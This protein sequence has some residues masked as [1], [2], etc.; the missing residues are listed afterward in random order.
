MSPRFSPSRLSALFG[1]SRGTAGR[2]TR[3]RHDRRQ[4]SP[5]TEQLENRKLLAVFYRG[6]LQTNTSST[7]ESWAYVVDVDA[8]GT[9]ELWMRYE[10]L[11]N[12]IDIADNPGFGNVDNFRFTPRPGFVG[13][14]VIPQSFPGPISLSGVRTVSAAWN[15]SQ[16]NFT[17]G[18]LWIRAAAGTRIHVANGDPLPLALQVLAG[19]TRIGFVPGPGLGSAEN[20]TVEG[21]IDARLN[22]FTSSPVAYD[23]Y[24]TA[25]TMSVQAAMSTNTRTQFYADTLVDLQ[26]VVTS[27]STLAFVGN[28]DFR[29]IAGAQ[30]NGTLGVYLGQDDFSD[31]FVTG[32]GDVGGNILIDGTVNGSSVTLNTNSKVQPVNIRTGPSG[33][34]SGGGSLTLFNSGLDGGEIDVRSQNYS[35][36]NVSAGAPNGPVPDIGVTINQTAG[37]LRVSAVPRSRGQI[38]LRASAPGSTIT[39][40][41]NVETEAGLALEAGALAVNRPL[42]TSAGNIVLTGDTV[43]VGSNVTAGSNGVGNIRVRSRTGR[44]TLSSA[45]VISAIDETISVEAATDIDSAARLETQFLDVKAGGGIVLKS[46]AAELRA[47][48]GGGITVSD[49]DSLLVR[50]AVAGKGDLKISA[51]GPL[52]VT[53]ATVSGAGAV[54]LDAGGDLLVGVARSTAGPITLAAQAGAVRV[55]G[56]VTVGGGTNGLTV[57]S[58]K[59]DVVIEP[60]AAVTVP[61]DVALS[62]PA[63]RVLTPGSIT[64]VVVDDPGTGYVTPPT[65]EFLSAQPAS[66]S[67]VVARAGVSGL[68]VVAGGT[69]YV[70][71]PTVALVGGGGRD[72]TARAFVTNGVVTSLQVTNPGTGYTSAPTVVFS[73]GSG[74]GAQAQALIGGISSIVVSDLGRGYLV[75]P[76]VVISSGDGASTGAITVN[77]DGG[78]VGINLSTPGA[79]Y[80]VPPLVEII[81]STGEGS[82]AAAEALITRGV[83][84]FNLTSGGSG[85]PRAPLVTVAPPPAGP[86]ARTAQVVAEILGSVASIVTPGGPIGGTGYSAGVR[87]VFLGGG[88]SGATAAVTISGSLSQAVIPVLAGG[89]GYAAVP[90]VTAPNPTGVAGTLQA[91]LGLT[92]SS[93]S[94]TYDP[95]TVANPTPTRYAVAP[96]ITFAAPPGGVA[97]VGRIDLDTTG[98]VVGVTILDPGYGYTSLVPANVTISGGIILGVPGRN[99][100]L[101]TNSTNF[102][103][104][105]VE[106]LTAGSGYTGDVDLVFTGPSTIPAQALAEVR[107]SIASV[108]L[109]SGGSRYTAAPQVQFIDA[110]GS[111]AGPLTTTLAASVTSL[112]VV[113][114]GA[115]YGTTAP[116]VSFEPLPGATPAT[117]TLGLTDVVARIVPRVA[118][119]GY[120]PATTTVRL[121]PIA[122]G[123]GAVSSAVTVDASGRIL[124]INVATGGRDY[125]APPTVTITDTSGSGRQAVATAI[126]SGGR[127]TGFTI[128]DPGIGYNAETT[129]VT[130]RSAGSG[131]TAVANLN[132]DGGVASITV[133]NSGSGYDAPIVRL[134]E[135]GSGARATA[136][137]AGGRV[138]GVTVLPG[139]GGANY[140][141]PPRVR[142][143]GGGG[144]GATG[145]AIVGGIAAINGGSLSWTALNGPL[146]AVLDSFSK[147]NINLT[148]PGDLVL[149]RTQ[150]SLTLLGAT[151]KDGSISIAAPSLTV[152]GAISAGNFSGK[153]DLAITLASTAGDLLIDA[154]VGTLVPG[155]NVPTP[156]T[157]L[158]TLRASNG[159][160]TATSPTKQGLVTTSALVVEALSGIDVRTNVS[161][162]R[163]GATSNAANVTVTQNFVNPDGN[164]LPLTLGTAEGPL[165]SSNGTITVTAGG[166][167]RVGSVDAQPAGTVILTGTSIDESV[168]DPDVDVRA[169]KATLTATNGRIKLDTNVTDLTAS[170]PLSSITLRN[171]SGAPLNATLA[172]RNGVN[173]TSDATINALSVAATEGEVAITALGAESDISIGKISAPGFPIVLSA[174]RSILQTD[175][176][177]ASITGGSAN[178]TAT[179][180]TLDLLIGTDSVRA[181]APGSISLRSTGPLQILLA[182]S[183]GGQPI[184][185][186]AAGTLSQSGPIVTTGL[187]TVTGDGV[188]DV[189]L[190][191]PDNAV[192]SFTGSNPGA[193]L[194]FRARNGLDVA[195]AGVTGGAIQLAAGGNLTQQGVITATV[196]LDAMTT[197]AGAV[198]L[199]RADNTFPSLTGSTFDGTF[200]VVGAGPFAVGTAGVVAG[201]SAPVAG[202]GSIALTTLTG[203]MTLI[204]NLTAVLD[205]ITLQAPAGTVIQTGTSRITTDTL[206]LSTVTP[207]TLLPA[208]NSIG[209][210]IED[211]GG[212]IVI[213]VPGQPI[214]VPAT[215]TTT[216][217]ISI[218]GSTV[219]VVGPVEATGT[220]TITVTASGPVS[221]GPAGL[222][223]ASAV[224]V[225]A[226]GDSQL[227][228]GSN[229][230]VAGATVSGGRLEL[231]SPGNLRQTGPIVATALAASSGSGSI[232]LGNP[233][234]NVA[235]FSA[236]AAHTGGNV[237]FVNAGGF[238]IG[239][240]G[241]T[242]GTAT[243]GDGLVTLTALTGNLTVGAPIT[244]PGDLVELRAPNGLVIQGSPIVAQTLIIIDSSGGGIPSGPIEVANAEALAGAIQVINSLPQGAL[245]EIIVTASFVLDRTLTVSNRVALTGQPAGVVLDGGGT[246]ANGLVLSSAASGSRITNLA[247]ANFTGTAVAIN[248]AQNVAVRGLTVVNSGTGLALSGNL[249]GTTVQGSTFRSV[250]VGMRLTDAQR[251]TLGGSPV[252]QRNRIEGASQAGVVA[253]G[254]CTGTRLINTTFTTSPPTRTRYNIRSSRNL[255]VSGTIVERPPRVARPV[256]GGRSPIS[257]L[258]R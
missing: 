109:G 237:V 82:G 186:T 21:P 166:A 97:A 257:L 122:G 98:Q 143:T 192:G 102:T 89:S 196:S 67:A 205:T 150:G 212:N 208:N 253:T 161:S 63:G 131:A 45:A 207:A 94:L 3:A 144:T 103:V 145:R 108:T 69:G 58:A 72:A 76:Q 204:G 255:R 229:V 152:A 135:Y 25:G 18:A 129:T 23:N 20:I 52:E 117:A 16:E 248:A 15:G 140:A 220:G 9:G 51:L 126:V 106:R 193:G 239:A 55:V 4:F 19:D 242:A 157:K 139:D 201:T 235:S 215:L 210:I 50:S 184:T 113:D 245:Y 138:T 164:V 219:N 173:L 153:P 27:P 147:V 142:F 77:D 191:S 34:L 230:P 39:I 61:G 252:A 130:L 218:V 211:L 40:D 189:V 56:N 127:V 62:A 119:R 243:P 258:G 92:S 175:P 99:L 31:L 88:G 78:I 254:F 124:R 195:P 49:D 232:G 177:V 22:T 47:V 36:T 182:E 65:V 197:A 156:V 226:V 151:T 33:V 14:A 217:N 13:P 221:F 120:N 68:Q 10:A 70:T 42:R 2:R 128:T 46:N 24:L 81:D 87:A 118:G 12:R 165:A 171:V 66:A 38:S 179:Q 85:Y 79:D 105:R 90:T 181:V 234:N 48:A 202:N 155:A 115:G 37:N 114:P 213:G 233:G 174:G 80:G 6:V 249:A 169:S 256:A 26:N 148:A 224:T 57:S 91:F 141:A 73:G 101:T 107:G 104:S 162:I 136:T 251:A 121:T 198:Q 29:L 17:S 225:S 7:E 53:T 41:S 159:A 100:A 176:A 180:G 246:T 227:R 71:A 116:A 112:R 154:P 214:T 244:A 11:Q 247:F 28:G 194:A 74:S 35:V 163:G 200:T 43:T 59:G 123:G 209:N 60:S 32:F 241:V 75:P 236:T 172:S 64:K 178:L 170:A 86:D 30:I 250:G 1:R 231:S 167:L 54:R 188:A 240:P 96:T 203:A 44:V 222:L 83:G 185:L 223:T 133:T 110:F 228:V 125:V 168:V 187:L 146:D 216:G 84:T 137:V 134:V 95:P 190:L 183:T 8:T 111:G 206:R 238:G 132:A 160:I 158:V 199:T 5:A 149:T 93:L